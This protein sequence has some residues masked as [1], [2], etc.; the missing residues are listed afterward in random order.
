M[1]NKELIEIS[2]R[3]RQVAFEAH[4]SAPHKFINAIKAFIRD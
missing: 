2:E 4:R 3:A 1:P